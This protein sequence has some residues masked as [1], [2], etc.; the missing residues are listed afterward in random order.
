[1]KIKKTAQSAGVVSNVVDSLNSTSAIDALS[2]NQ[3]RILSELIGTGGASGDT[4]PIGTVVDYNGDTVPE[5]WAV[6]EENID[7][8][9]LRRTEIPAYDSTATGWYP[10]L[11]ISPRETDSTYDNSAIVLL[12][13]QIYGGECGILYLNVRQSNNQYGLEDTIKSFKWLSN[14]GLDSLNFKLQ[15]QENSIILY[16]HVSFGHAVYNVRVLQEHTL[17]SELSFDIFELHNPQPEDYLTDE[18]SGVNPTDSWIKGTITANEGFSLTEGIWSL[19][20]DPQ[21][22]MVYLD[23]FVT[24]ST[25]LTAGGNCTP[26]TIP[27]EFCPKST[28]VNGACG[29]ENPYGTGSWCITDTGIMNVRPDAAS[30][31]I[32]MSVC[33]LG[34]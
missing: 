25:A 16:A 17:D 29:L 6:F 30:T 26:F 34:K 33:W 4:L 3:G 28:Y 24:S 14:S 9:S 1:M 31:K 20:K 5:N 11:T 21:T 7:E 19:V 27:E 18:P 2:A 13:S 8:N 10:M 23:V 22:K 32:G 12:I 15:V